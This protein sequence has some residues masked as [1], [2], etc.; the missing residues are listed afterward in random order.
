MATTRTPISRAAKVTIT[1][2]IITH[3]RKVRA[4]HDDPDADDEYHDAQWALH[5]MLDRKVWQED[6]FDT[7]NSDGPP[8]A[9]F[10][11]WPD[12]VADWQ[13]AHHLRV[14]L[15]RAVRQANP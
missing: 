15:D 4:L 11:Q 3:Y 1:S 9:V 7:I 12:R 13:G 14:E 8:A 10:Q 2:E 6:L 5:V